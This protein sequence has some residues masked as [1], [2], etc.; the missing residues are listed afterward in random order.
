MSLN[1]NLLWL[2]YGLFRLLLYNSFW[3]FNWHYSYC[4]FFDWLRRRNLYSLF[5]WHFF[6]LYLKRSRGIVFY[7]ISKIDSSFLIR[8]SIFCNF[9][10]VLPFTS[11]KIT[12]FKLILKHQL[13]ISDILIPYFYFYMFFITIFYLKT[14]LKSYL[15]LISSFC[16]IRSSSNS[17]NHVRLWLSNNISSFSKFY[18]YII[19][20]DNFC[21][22]LFNIQRKSDKSSRF[23]ILIKKL[24]FFFST[25]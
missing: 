22:H 13:I 3:R 21:W 23:F 6:I 19:N 11:L 7:F 15:V 10:C 17:H 4:L 16:S 25:W 20:G 8:W 1:F 24:Y 5:L 14:P 2:F 18:I 12:N 9:D